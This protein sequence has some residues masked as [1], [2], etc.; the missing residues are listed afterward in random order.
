MAPEYETLI[1]EI[2]SNICH[3]KLNRADKANAMNLQMWND[4]KQCFDWIADEP[5]VRAVVL[6]GEGKHFCSGMDLAVFTGIAEVFT[7]D[8]G[9]NSEK[10]RLMIK[11]LQENLSAIEKCRKPVLAAIHGA[12]VGGAIDMITC[13]DMRYCTEDAKFSIKEI[14]I[15]MTADVGTL[16]RL[17]KLIGDGIVR[18]LAYTGRY[19]YAD[20]ARTIG[21]VNKVFPDKNA[22][23]NGVMKLAVQISSKSPLAI[24]GI[25]EMLLYSRDH[26]VDDS[27]NYVST[28]NAAM[29]MSNDLQKTLEGSLAGKVP[30]Y[31][32]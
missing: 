6:S 10:L 16:Q 19:F 22:M 9:R 1:V 25:K 2:N 21:F 28:W 11:R 24:R 29:L 32:D 13:C 12:S 20:E 3:V 17:P 23:I 18:E 27:L 7:A 31:E 15:G 14:D 5:K 26:S 8:S 4:L 30:E